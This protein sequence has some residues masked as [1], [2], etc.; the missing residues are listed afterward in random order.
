MQ[1]YQFKTYKNGL[2]SAEISANG[3]LLK[4]ICVQTGRYL[5]SALINN[6]CYDAEADTLFELLT[7][8]QRAG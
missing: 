7:N 8:I 5:Y 6:K 3:M 4:V 2:Y 1:M